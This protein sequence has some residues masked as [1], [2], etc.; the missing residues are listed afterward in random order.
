MVDRSDLLSAWLGKHR[1]V[2]DVLPFGA[3]TGSPCDESDHI[4]FEW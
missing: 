2:A 1:P 4:V 3:I